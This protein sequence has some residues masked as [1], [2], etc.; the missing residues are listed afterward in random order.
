MISPI[1]RFRPASSHSS[2]ASRTGGDVPSS[3]GGGYAG[4]ERRRVAAPAM[5]CRV[6]GEED[7]DSSGS[8]YVGFFWGCGYGRD[9]RAR[10]TEIRIGRAVATSPVRALCVARAV[11]VVR[12]L[13]EGWRERS[14]RTY[15]FVSYGG[16]E[17]SVASA[18]AR[19][20]VSSAA[21][22]RP[23]KSNHE[24][25]SSA[26]SNFCLDVRP[27]VASIFL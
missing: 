19:S 26:A 5:L 17:P 6:Q 4:G 25:Y 15:D 21:S 3:G 12:R 7:W 16:G 22:G 27:L 2:F 24:A 10:R 13:A 9:L 14:C 18:S 20:Y 23:L 8:M 11:R 1:Y